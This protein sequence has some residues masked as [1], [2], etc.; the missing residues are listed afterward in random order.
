MSIVKTTHTGS[1]PRSQEVV[2]FIFAREHGK[3]YDTEAFDTCIT[4]AV[5]E[6]VRKQVAAGV[7]IVSDGETS[8]IS[9]A[10]Y[11]KD[12]YTGFDGDSP[13]NA[14]ADLKMFPGYL[15]RLAD[16]GGTPQY[17]RPMCVGEVRSNGQEELQRDIANLKAAM[18]QHGATRGFMNAASPGVISLFLQND[19]YPTREAYLAALADAMKAEY[20]TIVAAGL[21]LQLDCPDLAL[22]RHMLFTDLTDDEF[23]AVANSH[24]EALN[25]ALADIPA[26]RV[27]VHICWGNYEGPHC[28]D[29][30]MAKMFDTLMSTKSRYVLFET[31]NPR[32]GHEWTVFRDRKDDIPDDK[33]LVPGVVDTTT[34]FVE[35]PELVAERITRFAGIVGS[36]R[37]IAGSDCGFG[38][39]A[40]FGAVDPDIAYAKLAALAD[41]AALAS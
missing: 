41:G 29:I 23:I 17:A 5:S 30:P 31:S 7:D 15:K 2:D 28:C 3:P 18:A 36:E 25:H 8:K 21:D 9:Y 1:L 35:H 11:V 22:S 12:R 26:E 13:R 4:E 39:F 19:F 33:V 14:P 27:R 32:H 20:E 16:D 38:T 6:T 10:T 40:G 34:N 24:V 37:V